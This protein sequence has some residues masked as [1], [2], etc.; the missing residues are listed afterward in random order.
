MAE[1]GPWKSKRDNIY[2]IKSKEK[3]RVRN[4]QKWDYFISLELFQMAVENPRKQKKR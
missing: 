1:G 2:K 3:E 4:K